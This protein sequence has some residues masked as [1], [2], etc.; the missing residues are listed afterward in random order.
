MGEMISEAIEGAAIGMAGVFAVLA[1]LYAAIRL[2]AARG[3]SDRG[4][5]DRRA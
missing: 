2:L 4:E 5:P 1:A 3:G